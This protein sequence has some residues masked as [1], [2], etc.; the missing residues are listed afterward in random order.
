MG[1]NLERFFCSSQVK[2]SLSS[3]CQK[4]SLNVPPASFAS[5]LHLINH[6]H[7]GIFTPFNY[8]QNK[9]T[10]NNSPSVDP[11][12]WTCPK[13]CPGGYGNSKNGTMHEQ[14]K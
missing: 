8:T 13:G 10:L 6:M 2:T 4:I 7:K 1:L 11:K 9:T 14:P 3:F 5:P 12:G